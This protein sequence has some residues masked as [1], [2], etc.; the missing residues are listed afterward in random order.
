[1]ASGEGDHHHGDLG[2]DPFAPTP[3]RKL[4]A[5]EAQLLSPERN[6]LATSPEEAKAQLKQLL[7]DNERKIEEAGRLGQTLVNRQD[8][9]MESLKEVEVEEQSEGG[10]SRELARKL[11]E[12]EREFNEAGRD[13][14]RIL[15]SPSKS[16]ASSGEMGAHL[17]D[18]KVF[19]VC[20]V[21]MP[22]WQGLLSRFLA[23]MLHCCAYVLSYAIDIVLM[24]HQFTSYN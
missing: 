22:S 4:N 6:Q 14:S 5:F 17:Y 9:L 7:A 21:P 16:R 15:G 18:P 2:P 1:M 19:T 20:L 12:I 24:Q 10:I 8:E 13:S 3:T 23:V 11:Q